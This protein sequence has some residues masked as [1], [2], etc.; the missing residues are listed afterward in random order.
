M[1]YLMGLRLIKKKSFFFFK[2]KI[3]KIVIFYQWKICSFI[4]LE[5]F[6]SSAV[7]LPWM[8]ATLKFKVQIGSSL[9]SSLLVSVRAPLLF[10]IWEL[11]YNKARGAQVCGSIGS[12]PLISLP[13]IQ[14][15]CVCRKMLHGR[16]FCNFERKKSDHVDNF[17]NG[18]M[19]KYNCHII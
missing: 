9:F 11:P 8:R 16:M 4:R 5:P 7:C 1:L 15:G 12:V 10:H 3:M 19:R 2:K 13:G 17:L 18:N 14:K 6:I